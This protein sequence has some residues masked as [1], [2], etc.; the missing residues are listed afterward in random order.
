M[1]KKYGMKK[2]SFQKV[3]LEF[4]I[5]KIFFFKNEINYDFLHFFYSILLCKFLVL[6]FIKLY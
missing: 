6:Y 1:A 5:S 2:T 4:P 3:Y